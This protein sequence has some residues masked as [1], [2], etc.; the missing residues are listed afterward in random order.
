[1]NLE[2]L[3][4]LLI[5]AV[6]IT[7]MLRIFM[8]W[9]LAGWL[10]FFVLAMLGG[11]VGWLLKRWLRLPAVYTFPFPTDGV[12]VSVVWTTVGALGL[13]LLAA[14]LTRPGTSRRR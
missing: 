4:T 9:S 8:G 2:T 14:L 10:L 12:G 11:V 6:V 5:V 7:T 1:M 3:L 13:T